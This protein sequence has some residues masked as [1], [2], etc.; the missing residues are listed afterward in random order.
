MAGRITQAHTQTFLSMHFFHLL[1]QFFRRKAQRPQLFRFQQLVFF[2]CRTDRLFGKLR[3]KGQVLFC[4]GTS[5]LSARNATETF[6][7][8]TGSFQIM[9]S[10]TQWR[11]MTQNQ[12]RFPGILQTFQ[13]GFIY[14][15][16]FRTKEKRRSPTRGIKCIFV[17][18]EIIFRCRTNAAL[19]RN[20]DGMRLFKRDFTLRFH[21]RLVDFVQ[22]LDQFLPLH[23]KFFQNRSHQKSVCGE[24]MATAVQPRFDPEFAHPDS[25]LGQILTLNQGRAVVAHLNHHFLPEGTPGRGIKIGELFQ[26]VVQTWIQ[27]SR[28]YNRGMC[29][30]AHRK[31]TKSSQRIRAILFRNAFVARSIAIKLGHNVHVDAARRHLFPKDRL[32]VKLLLLIRTPCHFQVQF[33][34]R[35]FGWQH[36]KIPA[37]VAPRFKSTQFQLVHLK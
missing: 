9:V 21:R 22:G 2:R 11:K 27:T 12:V 31:A 3:V 14:G 25:F 34:Q 20:P 6:L 17:Q 4:T 32:Q 24:G 16:G 26:I 15:C 5:R 19:C 10:N 8:R 37:D 13:R 35:T 23:F 18:K 30:I 29:Q 33:P 1:L 28:K 36:F 7:I